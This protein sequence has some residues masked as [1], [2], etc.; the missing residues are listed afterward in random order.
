MTLYSNC[1]KI[2]LFC[3]SLIFV[4][5]SITEKNKHPYD[6][7]NKFLFVVQITEVGQNNKINYFIIDIYTST[8]TV[9]LKIDGDT[10]DSPSQ[11]EKYMNLCRRNYKVGYLEKINKRDKGKILVLSTTLAD[12]NDKTIVFSDKK[13]A[14][15]I[16]LS[17]LYLFPNMK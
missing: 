11:S 9:D 14:K 7:Q 3:I 13:K 15:E 6:S 1:K 5:C 8:E 10:I 2:K 4:S 16:S 17:K 12:I